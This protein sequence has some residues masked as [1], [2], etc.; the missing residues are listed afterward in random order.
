MWRSA[1]HL[2]DVYWWKISCTSAYKW[3]IPYKDGFSHCIILHVLD[4]E[5]LVE[6]PSS[7]D[8]EVQKRKN[9]KSDSPEKFGCFSYIITGVA[10]PQAATTWTWIGCF[11]IGLTTTINLNLHSSSKSSISEVCITNTNSEALHIEHITTRKSN[12]RVN[13]SDVQ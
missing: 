13:K 7:R 5:R 8:A 4:L 1:M 10:L 2:L 12:R 6:M 11:R 3:S 9:G